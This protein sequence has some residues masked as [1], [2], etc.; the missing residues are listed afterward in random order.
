MNKQITVGRLSSSY[1]VQGWVKVVSYTEN[2]ADICQ[3]TPWYLVNKSYS[4]IVKPLK[5][6]EHLG[7]LLVKLDAFDSK[8]EVKKLANSTIK[9]DAQKLPNLRKDEIYWYQLEGL[10]VYAHDYHDNLLLGVVEKMIPGG[11]QDLLSII[12]THESVDNR[13]RLIPWVLKIFIKE[14]D[15][16]NSRILVDWGVDY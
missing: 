4:C 6:R 9:V 7:S 16:E 12:P 13:K 5:W 3:Y 14:V 11:G 1:G 2:V 8:E 15:T 10:R